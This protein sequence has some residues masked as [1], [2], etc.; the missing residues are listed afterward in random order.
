MIKIT[1]TGCTG[2]MGRLV[3]KE[4]NQN[5]FV[6]ISGALARPGNPFVGQDVG[7]LIGESPLNIFISDQ[8]ES[9]FENADI[10]I[11]FSR[12][13]AF[14]THLKTAVNHQKPFVSC[15]TGL[16]EN[17]QKRLQESSRTIPILFAPNTS[18]GIVLLRK[19]AQM[20]AEILGPSYDVSLLEMHHRHK[21]DAPS[22]TSLTLGKSLS[23]IEHLQSNQSPCPSESPRSS[24]TIEYAVLRG[25]GVIGDHSVIFAGEKDMITLEHRALDRGLFAQGALQ[26]AQWLYGKKA[27]YYTIDDVVRMTL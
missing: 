19:L 13:E 7:V 9:A 14:E 22:G 3:L 24:G 8:P 16:N 20:A 12:P 25:G 11:E 21:K 27:G 26:A 17:Q 5:P 4:I 1:V 23:N 10:V 6:E 2:R 18:L 15:I